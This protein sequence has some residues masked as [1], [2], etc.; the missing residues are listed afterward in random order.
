MREK[1][2]LM[3]FRGYHA[4]FCIGSSLLVSLSPTAWTLFQYPPFH[5]FIRKIWLSIKDTPI[6]LDKSTCGA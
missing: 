3:A 4:D 5:M 2:I 1:G 6:G